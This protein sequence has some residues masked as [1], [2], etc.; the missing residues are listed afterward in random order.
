MAVYTDP[1]SS[2]TNGVSLPTYSANWAT[3]TGSTSNI[4]QNTGT[5]GYKGNKASGL[6]VNYYNNTFAASHYAQAK[7]AVLGGSGN[8]PGVA[9]RVQTGADSCFY[10]IVDPSG[11]TVYNGQLVSGSS[12]DWDSGITGAGNVPTVGDTFG[13]YV[14]ATTSTTIYYKVNGVIKATYTSKNAL[15]GGKAGVACYD[16]GSSNNANTWEG[17]DSASGAYTITGGTGS[18]TET[19]IAAGL[20]ADRFITG[21]VG[22]YTLTGIDA[23]LVYSSIP[24]NYTLTAQLGQF[25]LNGQDATTTYSVLNTLTWD[26]VSGNEGYRIEW[27]QTSSGPYPNTAD[28]A[29][30]DETYDLVLP[31]RTT[32]YARIAA[33][34]AGVP[35]T[36]SSEIAFT[37]GIGDLNADVSSYTLTGI[38]VNL[39]IGR[40]TTG[41]VGTFTLTGTTAG[42]GVAR[43][44]AADTASFTLTGT[45]ATLSYSGASS[46]Y[47]LTAS[48][49]AFDL[50]GVDVGT[51]KGY[52]LPVDVGSFI[53]NGINN[54]LIYS[55]NVSSAT[56][57]HILATR[58]GLSL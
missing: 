53:V 43:S 21:G 5:P 46:T 9:I 24:T 49:A 27:G 52:S 25:S 36:Y 55:G 17:G 4:I 40:K 12:T 42:L 30:D 2:G 23:T 29:V 16:D 54:G 15:T 31:Y 39:G 50:S 41:G 32:W 10:C 20:K 18:F 13:L 34:I 3:P 58:L 51:T 35:Q 57:M 22:N 33:L 8:M 26:R 38:D 11:P 45:S 37:S 6:S 44:V 56:L 28:N 19:G 1:F 47:T 14:D 7:I 48:S